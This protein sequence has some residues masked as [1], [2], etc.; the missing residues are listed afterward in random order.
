MNFG[1]LFGKLDS[2]Q[3]QSIPVLFYFSPQL[4]DFHQNFA[5]IMEF[6]GKSIK[7]SS[8]FG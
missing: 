8:T 4:H 2:Q 7:L 3:C 5:S 1:S 6:S